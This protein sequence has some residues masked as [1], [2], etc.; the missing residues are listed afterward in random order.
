MPLMH[1]AADSH[2]TFPF[3]VPRQRRA[4]DV[5]VEADRPV[6]AFIID[7]EQ[8]ARYRAGQGYQTIGTIRPAL[9]HEERVRVPPGPWNLVIVNPHNVAVATFYELT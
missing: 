1:L 2:F 7:D 8:L 6:R 5:F 9:R 4:V 3:D